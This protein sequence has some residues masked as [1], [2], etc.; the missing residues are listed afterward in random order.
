M[1]LF[2][3][4]GFPQGETLSLPV[5]SKMRLVVLK[6]LTLEKDMAGNSETMQVV[7]NK[8]AMKHLRLLLVNVVFF[9]RLE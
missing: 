7:I 2:L 5:L 3:I 1:Y 9:I 6:D 8:A 4:T